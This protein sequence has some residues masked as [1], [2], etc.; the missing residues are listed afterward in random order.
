MMITFEIDGSRFNY[1]T[2]GI[3]LDGERV[4]IHRSEMDDFWSLPGGR[5]EM[6]ESAEGALRREMREEL[7]I[8]VH[9][10]RLVW[11]VENFFEYDGNPYHEIAFYFLMILPHDSHLYGRGE[12]FAGN[13]EGLKLTFKWYKIDELKKL[14]L[15]P[16][17]LKDRLRSIPGNTE[18]IVHT[19]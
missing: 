10:G 4:L 13:E 5:V 17:F 16:A 2:V 15:Y 14:E 9:I 12:S 18:H 7:E 11:I 6:M 8:D 3:V 19:D 1:R